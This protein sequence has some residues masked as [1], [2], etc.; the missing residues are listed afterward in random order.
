[1]AE[2]Q[3]TVYLAHIVFGAITGVL[4]HRFG[5]RVTPL[6]SPLIDILRGTTER[7]AS[8]NSARMSCYIAGRGMGGSHRSRRSDRI[9]GA[10]GT[11]SSSAVP[12][13]RA[14][15]A[16]G[17]AES[18]GGGHLTERPAYYSVS[19]RR[20]SRSANASTLATD[21]GDTAPSRSSDSFSC[22]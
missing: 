16:V 13:A 6:W 2:F 21:S 17:R 7:S 10:T 22:E 11:D 12:Q 8:R 18:G 15:V 19:S 1:M 4:I 3:T 5:S 9:N 20:I 14:A